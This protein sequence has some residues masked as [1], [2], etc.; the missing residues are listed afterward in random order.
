MAAKMRSERAAE[1]AALTLA[2]S[3]ARQTLILTRTTGFASERAEAAHRP[4]SAADEPGT[5]AHS[6]EKVD[7]PSTAWRPF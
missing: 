2:V 4:P 7:Q 6:H 1:P 3:R 5:A